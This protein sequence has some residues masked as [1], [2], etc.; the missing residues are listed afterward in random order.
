MSTIRIEEVGG[1]TLSRA[2]K[3]LA[4]IPGGTQKAVKRAMERAV[5]HLRTNS[6]KAIQEKYDISKAGVRADENI[7]IRYTIGEGVTA[8][9][10]FRGEKIPLFRYGGASPKGPA[11]DKSKVIRAMVHGSWRHV[12]PGVAARGHQLKSTSPTRFDHAFVAQMRSGHIGIFAR[13]GGASISRGDAVKEIM[14]S[15]VPQ[16]L[17]NE[18]VTEKLSK[19][20]GD[21]F[22][23]RLEHEITAILNAW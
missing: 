14:G 6:T 11:Q 2:E 7:S 22:E 10:T 20:T 17:G 5:S 19:E 1:N 23:K 21:K 13:T 3:L 18:E 15:S 4:G 8:F 16:M 9:V 12:H